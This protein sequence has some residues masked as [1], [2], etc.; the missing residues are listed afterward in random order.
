MLILAPLILLVLYSLLP[1]D[2]DLRLSVRFNLNAAVAALPT[3]FSNRWWLA[4]KKVAFPV[5]LRDEVAL[6]IKSGYGTKGRIAPWL[7]AH[8]AAEFDNLLLVGDF[9]TPPGRP[10]D[11]HGRPVPVH[12]VVAQM[13]Q[14]GSLP[15]HLVHPRLL[16]YSNLTAAIASGDDDTARGLSRSFGWELDALKFIA[17]LELCYQQMPDKKW[18]VMA[19]DDTYLV[20]PSVLRLLEH[21]DPTVP[22]YVGNAVGDYKARFAHGGSSLILSQ[23]TMRTLFTDRAAVWDAHMEALEE[24]W[25]DKLVA[26]VLIKIGIYLDER[27]AIFFNGEQPPITKISAERFCAPIASFHGLAAAS[28]MLSV[29]ETFERFA[30]PVLWIDLWDLY[31]APSFDA[32]VLGTGH[33]NWD[34]VGRLDEHT[35][36]ISDVISADNCRRI[37]Q[38]RSSFCLAWTWDSRQQACH[39]SPWMIVGGTAKG[40]TSGINVP[41]AKRLAA[42]CR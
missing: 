12:D 25:G 32:P 16:K 40:K 42:E 29:G 7:Q 36:S 26:T 41:R 31:R 18:Y 34:Y 4:E 6:V 27:H 14:N 38:G 8:E 3:P 20:Q 13:L 2:H 30:D 9:S 15:A 1:Y 28:D 21:L 23:A 5:N 10:Y 24:K 22:Y 17:G 33:A 39:L 37:C 19:D 35:M 11:Y